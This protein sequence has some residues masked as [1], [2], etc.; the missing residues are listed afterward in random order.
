MGIILK[1]LGVQG[2]NP[3]S[4]AGSKWLADHGATIES[5]NPANNA[6]IASVGLTTPEDYADILQAAQEAQSRWALVPISTRVEMVRH[7]GSQLRE[8]SDYLSTLISLETGKSKVAGDSEVQAMIAMAD[9]AIGQAHMQSGTGIYSEQ[10]VCRYAEQWRPLGICGI[11]TAFDSAAAV[12][13]KQALLAV[14][15]G[16]VVVWK[17]SKKA[18]LVAVAIQHICQAVMERMQI[19][20]IFSLINSDDDAFIE[21]MVNDPRM[22]LIA[23]TGSTELGNRVR[24][25][26]SSR[27]GRVMLPVVGYH[28]LIIDPSADTNMVI[29]AVAETCTMG[30]QLM[31]HEHL[32]DSIIARLQHAYSQVRIGDPLE[33]T[34]QMGPLIDA[35]SVQRFT[36]LMER[37]QSI[38][39]KVLYGGSVLEQSGNF[40]Q[41]TL[42]RVEPSWALLQQS[43]GLPIVFIMSYQD[44][45]KAIAHNNAQ[46]SGI[47]SSLFATDIRV[48]THFLSAQGSNSEVLNI[49]T[50]ASEGM[51][52]EAW[53]AYMQRQ[54]VMISDARGSTIAQK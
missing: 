20:G 44:L 41:P 37:I 3:G 35:E 53:K 22:A 38:G 16:N 8:K 13:A 30:K 40:V 14:I 34:N 46:Q 10:G 43:H 28:T 15:C 21:D 5:L 4:S 45:D 27:L 36:D 33:V 42:V 54:T 19:D 2:R 25:K 52:T 31:V 9:C 48:I 6:L 39:G 1:Q 26:V 32:I 51:N 47:S 23:F 29:A 18:P 7:I 12:W 50:I 24:G 11:V 49:N 17:P